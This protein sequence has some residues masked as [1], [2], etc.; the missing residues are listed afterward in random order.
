MVDLQKTD[1]AARDKII[2]KTS[3]IGIAANILLATFKAIIGMIT[4]SIAIVLDAVNNFSD[5]G[6]SLITIIGTRLAAKQPDKE[7]PWG[8]GRIEYLSAMLIAGLI[9]YAG[10]TALIQSVK[11]I[12]SPEMPDYSA[13]AIIIVAS[14]VIV[15]IVLGRFVKK[16][17]EEVRSESLVNS[18]KDAL[19]D[20]IIS[21]STLAAAIIFLTTGLRTEAWIGAA[22]S[23]F[24]IKSGIDM[25]RDTVSE[26]LGQRIDQ[27]TVKAVHDTIISFPQI[28]GVYDLIFHD[29]GPDKINCSA[30]IEIPHTMTADE[31]DELQRHVTSKVFCEH[32]VIVTAL[33]VYAVNTTDAEM[34]A[35]RNDVYNTAMS[36]RHVL[37]VHGFYFREE[38]K[39]IQFDVIVDFEAKDRNKVYL[40]V[41]NA[42]RNKFPDYSVICT[43]DTDFSVSE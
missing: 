41:I 25:L 32:G 2:I 38:E 28:H 4:H 40:E 21:A 27:E 11:K 7:H 33:S 20:S 13:A 8:H 9:I 17:G 3:I 1:K 39:R 18:G 24:I 26:L 15:K 34:I 30:H 5:V 36:I 14:A 6:S 35:M 23:L 29:Y 10:I 31:I 37:Q 12:I 42:V 16:R 43:L 22:I 19:M